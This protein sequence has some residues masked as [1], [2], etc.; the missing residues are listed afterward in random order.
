MARD[1]DTQAMGGSTRWL[2]LTLPW[3]RDSVNPRQ[4]RCH[5]PRLQSLPIQPRSPTAGDRVTEVTSTEVGMHMSENTKESGYLKVGWTP[6]GASRGKR[7][8]A[9]R[10]RAC[11]SLSRYQQPS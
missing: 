1:T 5:L 8:L 7:G 9:G 6:E 10:L 4:V 11:S 3:D 2:M